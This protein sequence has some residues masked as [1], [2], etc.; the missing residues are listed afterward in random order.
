[1]V[2]VRK[3]QKCQVAGE[4]GKSVDVQDSDVESQAEN[5]VPL[6]LGKARR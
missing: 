1:M 6:E 4:G 3:R 5:V 2:P